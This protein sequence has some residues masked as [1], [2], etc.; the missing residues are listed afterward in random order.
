MIA[1]AAITV[2]L[3]C[4]LIA[5]GLPPVAAGM[6]PVALYIGREQAQA[7]H[8]I[9]QQRFGR[10]ALAPWWA[11][12]TPAAWTRKAVGDVLGPIIAAATIAIAIAL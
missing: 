8:R 12:F 7:E 1:H 10:R 9:I 2:A 5:A 3:Q 11:G 4:A 6:V